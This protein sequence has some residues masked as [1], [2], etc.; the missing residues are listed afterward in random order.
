MDKLL[1]VLGSALDY[2]LKNKATPAEYFGLLLSLLS[3]W[4]AKGK[5]QG[6]ATALHDSKNLS[7]DIQ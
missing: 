1:L 6:M 3:L 2:A 4:E 7:I 5:K